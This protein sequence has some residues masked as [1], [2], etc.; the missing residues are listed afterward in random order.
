MHFVNFPV[1][2]FEIAD[3]F[4][5]V[6]TF[7]HFLVLFFKIF[8]KLTHFLIFLVGLRQHLHQFWF[9]TWFIFVNFLLKLTNLFFIIWSIILNDVV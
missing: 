8:H 7:V 1:F 4:D 5:P 2:L 6:T 3:K 9:Q